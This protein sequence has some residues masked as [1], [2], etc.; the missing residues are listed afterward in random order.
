MNIKQEAKECWWQNYKKHEEYDRKE[1]ITRAKIGALRY[2]IWDHREPDY[3]RLR[4]IK[5]QHV[6]IESEFW[7]SRHF[8][9]PDETESILSS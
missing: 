4:D 1:T 6:S 7:S 2:E 9:E 5:E 8:T 3:D